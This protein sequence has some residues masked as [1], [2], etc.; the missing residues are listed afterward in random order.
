MI[1]KIRNRF[2]QKPKVEAPQ[3]TAEMS[4]IL[5]DHEDQERIT[6]TLKTMSAQEFEDSIDPV[7]PCDRKTFD[8]K[9]V[10]G[11][12]LECAGSVVTS[13]KWEYKTGSC[14]SNK[15]GLALVLLADIDAACLIIADL[16]KYAPGLLSRDFTDRIDRHLHIFVI[17]NIVMDMIS[18][19]P[20][21]RFIV[22][23]WP[24]K[25]LLEK[26]KIL[27][28]FTNRARHRQLA[29]Q[30]LASTAPDIYDLE[31]W[32]LRYP[33]DFLSDMALQLY[34]VRYWMRLKDVAF[35][36]ELD[37]V[38]AGSE[39]PPFYRLFLPIEALSWSE[40]VIKIKSDA[41]RSIPKSIEI[42]GIRCF[43]PNSI[44]GPRTAELFRVARVEH[45][46]KP[47]LSDLPHI[48]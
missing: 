40:A 37:V 17:K 26:A 24:K 39:L 12:A 10:F 23:E 9:Y 19:T 5:K 31:D 20:E 41:P 11:Y 47:R 2:R 48:W 4:K 18:E 22:H 15:I 33:D 16:A 28:F 32:D 46:M 13:L 7:T 8:E 35:T 29:I 6:A 27:A 36:D 30:K 34:P 44:I 3:Q 21:G 38:C 14:Q 1:E 45:R 43:I 25:P 42:D